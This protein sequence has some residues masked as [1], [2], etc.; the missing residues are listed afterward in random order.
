[1]AVAVGMN[2]E[3]ETGEMLELID[4]VIR[5]LDDDYVRLGKK[6]YEIKHEYERTG[7]DEV[8]EIRKELLISVRYIAKRVELEVEELIGLLSSVEGK[9]T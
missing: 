8:P 5:E 7:P 9:K 3:K 4:E 6:I 1:L 2:E